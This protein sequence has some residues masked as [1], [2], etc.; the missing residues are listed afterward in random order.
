MK[1]KI[2]KIRG[3][4]DADEVGT[5]VILPT[6]VLKINKDQ[7][8]N[9]SFGIPVIHKAP[10]SSNIPKPI[11]ENIF[12]VGNAN[13]SETL[14]SKGYI[15][16]SPVKVSGE[17]PQSDITPAKFTFGSP[18]HQIDKDLDNKRDDCSGVV[19]KSDDIQKIPPTSKEWK[20]P[21]CW[22]D[23]KA[24]SKS[25][26]C[27][28]Y[29]NSSQNAIQ[30]A[31]CS[32]CKLADSQFE[33][34]KCGNCEKMQQLKSTEPLS[35]I[36]LATGNNEVTKWKCEDC[37]ISN[38]DSASK[39][40]CCG[41]KKPTAI[42]G[43]PN[44]VM[45]SISNSNSESENWRCEDCWISN[46]S[47]V[48][49]CAACGG[50]KP[51][52]KPAVPRETSFFGSTDDKFKKIVESQK[53]AKWECSSCLVR[54]DS[55]ISKCA[56]CGQAK[57]STNKIPESKFN[58][59]TVPNS[60]FKFG[61]DP[62]AQ[63]T[64]KVPELKYSLGPKLKELSEKNNNVLS[65]VP[66]FT[67]TLPTKVLGN[68]SENDSIPKEA[69]KLNFSFGIPKPI[70]VPAVVAKKIPEPQKDEDT[71]KNQEVPSI[72][73]NSVNNKPKPF[74]MFLAP[75]QLQ[76]TKE[77]NKVTTPA[78]GISFQNPISTDGTKEMVN[79]SVTVQPTMTNTD[80]V[81]KPAFTFGVKPLFDPPAS[82]AAPAPP[83]NLF[84]QQSQPTAQPV[85]SA[86]A[87]S[88]FNPP[89]S[90]TTTP[91]LFQPPDMSSVTPA[92]LFQKSDT[93][94]TVTP[95][96]IFNFGANAQ[97]N[98]TLPST[99]EKSNFQFTFGSNTTA[100]S[101]QTVPNLFQSPFGSTDNNNTTPN[102]FGLPQGAL[103]SANTN[104]LSAPNGLSG[105]VMGTMSG[106]P[107]NSGIGMVANGLPVNPLTVGNTLTGGSANIFGNPIKNE[108]MW[109]PA[110]NTSTP[111]MFV[112]NTITSSLQKP[113]TFTFGS[114]TSFGNPAPPA[115]GNNNA[116]APVIFGMNNQNNNSNNQ[117]LMFPGSAPSQPTPNLFGSP[118]PPSNSVP[119]MGMF[120]TPN[121]GA[122]PT[123]GSP[124]PAIPAFEPPSPAPAP[125]FNFGAQQSTA[126]FGFGQQVNIVGIVHVT[127]L[128]EM[129]TG[130]H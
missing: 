28:G 101:E 66:S 87:L 31:K 50:A 127:A 69:P 1:T 54:N 120:G 20:C 35:T 22:V 83:I 8:P 94:S 62:K 25:C 73:N 60:S 128:K 30:N 121:I 13:K 36:S 126:I 49:K 11:S 39:C 76:I 2:T 53:S 80:A 124:N 102:S 65:E 46:K 17:N 91:N 26:A 96:P 19:V 47:S 21:D 88:L 103:G 43:E 117:P 48:D 113:A 107:G 23:N 110:N 4:T 5:P 100:K 82:T 109:S 123:F 10:V 58:F 98:S 114:S 104:G 125:A 70:A 9:I 14:K 99:Q 130:T 68:N 118:Q 116:Q 3:N 52:S 122:T 38:E 16:A 27:C 41:A 7:L 112:S 79:N 6:G 64:A 84:T 12:S 85:N 72:D 59:G 93:N 81:V 18:E 75:A 40:A 95:A 129:I 105:N 92:P 115:F 108:N 56:C 61:I 55:D 51:D 37:W 90:T 106:N 45:T 42:G 33:K 24:E 34:D 71:E 32:V 15:F 89:V 63:E 111:N 74:G 77:E 119:Q 97:N 57:E 78:S 67:F 86:P 44:N 29:K